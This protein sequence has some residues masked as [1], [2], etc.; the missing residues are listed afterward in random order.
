MRELI[1]T[2]K[3][4]FG[5]VEGFVMGWALSQRP[6]VKKKECVGCGECRD[7]C[8]AKAITM[9]K[10]KPRIDRKACIRCFCCQEFCPKS[11]MKVHRTLIA[12][13]LD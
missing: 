10:Q 5:R 3:S 13:L 2:D 11:A 7:I 4:L 6:V 9:V 1:L 8:P 12:R